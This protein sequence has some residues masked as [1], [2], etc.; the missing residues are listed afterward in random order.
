MTKEWKTYVR[1]LGYL[2][3][4][5]G[6]LLSGVLCGIIFAGSSVGW[7]TAANKTFGHI[8]NYEADSQGKIWLLAL[9]LPVIA[10]IRGMGQYL[11]TYLIQWVG[12]RVITD[13]RIQAFSHLQNLSIAF[14]DANKTGEMISRTINDTALLERSVSFAVEDIVKQPFLLLGV[15]IYLFVLDWK[16]AFASLVLFPL[17]MIPVL[18]YGRKVRKAGREGQERLADLVSIM[19]ESIVG[20]RIVKSFCNE[21]H[22]LNRFSEQCKNFFGRIMKVV[23]ASASVQ[24]II[25]F[26]SS[27]GVACALIYA[28]AVHMPW[29]DFITFGAGL[30]MLYDPIKS[31]SKLHMIIQH[32]SGAADRIFEI[33]DMQPTVIEMP[34]AKE[35]E[36]VIESIVFEHVRF[37]YGNGL[38]LDDINLTVKRGE[39]IAIVGP[40]GSGKTTL[41]NLLPRFFDVSTGRI[42]INGH[43]IRELKLKS[44]RRRIGLVT[45]ETVLFNDTVAY[46]ISYG[47][48][49]AIRE[50]IE[51]TARCAH[52]HDFISKLEHGYDTIIGPQGKMLSGGERQRI[53]IARAILTDPS[54]LILDEATSA[55][56]SQSERLVQ[57]ALEDVIVGRTVFAVAH[58]L[59]TVA[60]FDRIIVMDHGKIVEQGV[61]SALLERNGLYRKLYD[62][63]FGL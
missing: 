61:P 47:N 13:L 27:I 50:E 11:S 34:D 19:Q 57:K 28:R 26:I 54:V 22:E 23:R 41:L 58:R 8:F 35:C 20:V 40:S 56:D 21:Q 37:S 52:A 10:L 2:K 6:R 42:L 43:D 53:A 17:C 1:L 14:Y 18:L 29:Q 7:L 62:M 59:S 60:N 31:L 9:A 51:R 38:V 5:K 46:N 30:V 36:D 4:Y 49:S 55:L 45:Q 12:N 63:Q 39:K 44:L 3:P 16:L 48:P 32:S 33:L 25:A 24:P 15:T